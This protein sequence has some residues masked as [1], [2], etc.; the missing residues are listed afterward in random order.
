[1]TERVVVDGAGLAGPD[2]TG[3][4]PAQAEERGNFLVETKRFLEESWAEFSD[5]TGIDIAYEGE[6]SKLNVKPLTAAAL[7][8]FARAAPPNPDSWTARWRSTA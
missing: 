1:M 8:N 5:C 6:I 4:V 2:D 7:K 3:P